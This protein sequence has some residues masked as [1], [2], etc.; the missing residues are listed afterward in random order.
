MST[1][2]KDNKKVEETRESNVINDDT[3]AI[4]LDN[5]SG[6]IKS[7][8]SGQ[9]APESVLKS[10][11]G[12]PLYK[13]SMIGMTKKKIFCGKELD[14]MKGVLELSNPIKNG[15]ITNWDNLE[16][17]WQYSFENELRINTNEHNILCSD[18][19]LNENNIRE[20]MIE[21]LFEKFNFNGSFINNEEILSLYGHGRTTGLVFSS[22]H[23]V[24]Y[25]VPI[26]EG[27]VLPFGIKKI[28]IGGNDINKYLKNL[29]EKNNIKLFTKNNNYQFLSSSSLQIIQNIK[30][31]ICYIANNYN[32]EIN[33]TLSTSS[34]IKEYKLP[35]GT[36][37]N[38]NKE[39]FECCELLYNPNIIGK[40]T[41]GINYL[42]KESINKCELDIRNE[43][44]KN[45]ILNGGNTMFNNF[46]TRLYN[47]LNNI[48]NN[49]DCE[50]KII[51][52]PERK[53]SIWIGG[54][55]LSSLST[56]QDYWI[57]NKQY[58]EHGSRIIHQKL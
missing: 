55:I 17:L 54:A 35:D 48:I 12:K 50:I 23:T 16:K 2:T 25:S 58:Q 11:V 40:Q 5:G 10:I 43:L 37:I 22:G 4:V 52:Q 29:I 39:R 38:L 18:K 21:L 19:P 27:F 1:T 51:S 31:K 24:T 7:G 13:S 28:N 9:D 41:N 46:D 34:S 42:I 26:F 33:K 45:I 32:D 3:P 6:C 53:Y 15:I 20:K 44:Y 47:E 14:K 56:F 30:E 57:T 49:N 36:I 8:F